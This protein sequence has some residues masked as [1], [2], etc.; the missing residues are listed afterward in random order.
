MA[1]STL[2]IAQIK[3]LVSSEEV[4]QELLLAMSADQRAGVRE[5]ALRLKRAN[6]VREKEIKRLKKLFVYED[7]LRA[8]GHHLV[9]GVDEVGRGPL[10]GPVAAAAVILPGEVWLPGLN[11]SKKLSP[12]KR[13]VLAGLIKETALDFAIGEASPEEIYRENIHHASL[14]AMRRSVL[15]LKV[16]PAYVLVDGFC[17]EGLALP[18]KPLVGGDGLSASIAAASIV[19]KVYRDQ[20]MDAYHETYPEY[21]FNKHKGYATPDHLRAL[22][23]YGPCPIHRAGYRPVKAFAGARQSS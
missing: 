9:A 7:E 14:A 6:A 4:N 2:S 10:A 3:E 22:A 23:R 1:L 15:K 20:L 18:Q 19:A 17:I 11:D 21:G 8:C 16:K 12:A 5:L 13:E